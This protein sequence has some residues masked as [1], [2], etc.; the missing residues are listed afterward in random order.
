[1]RCAG[2]ASMLRQ[3][4]GNQTEIEDDDASLGRYQYV[5]GFDISVKLAS[6]MKC[7]HPFDQ[8]PKR[9]HQPVVG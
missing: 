6:S 8:L 3:Q 9:V 4:F 5:G 2:V 7:G 1:M